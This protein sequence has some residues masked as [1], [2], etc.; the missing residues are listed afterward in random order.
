MCRKYNNDHSSV[1]ELMW[2]LHWLPIRARI[3]YKLLLL[4]HKAF[5]GGSLP[6]LVDM[7]ITR[8]T[9]RS[10]RSFHSVNL[11]V[12]PHHGVNKYSEK[13][14]AVAGPLLTDELRGCNSL[15]TFKKELKTLL[16]QKHTNGHVTVFH[17]VAIFCFL[18]FIL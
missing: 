9:T 12:L 15:N 18:L 7:M 17:Y 11:L 8:N 1:T 13:A 2:G 5:T 6:Y 4:V 14:F 10:T 3:Q 16:F